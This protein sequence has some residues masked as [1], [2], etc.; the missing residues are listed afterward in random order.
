MCTSSAVIG[1]CLC[2][3]NVVDGQHWTERIHVYILCSNWFM[4]MISQCC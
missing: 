1:S 2:F 3:L 4:S